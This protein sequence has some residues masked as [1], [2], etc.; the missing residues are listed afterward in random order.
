MYK[1]LNPESLGIAGR[2][3]ELIELTLT[4][5]YRGLDVDGADL[6]K[7]ASL[8]GVDEAA[9]YLRSG[10]VK[11]SGF[12]LP[13]SITAEEARYKT[14]LEKLA[15]QAEI[16]QQLGFKY[17]EMALDPASDSLPYVTNFEKHRERLA[18]AADLLAKHE[19]CV[20]LSLKAAVAHRQGRAH[21]FIHKAEEVLTLMKTISSTNIAL[22]LD[23][24]NWR[25]G[26][27]GSDQ[28]EQLKAHQ[29]A[30]V[31]IADVPL[32][33]DLATVT[34][35]ERLL[36]TEETVPAHA[37]LLR[38]LAEREYEGPVTLYPHPNQVPAANRDVC[39]QKISAQLDQ[40]WNAAGLNKAGRLA[41][42]PA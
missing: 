25:V 42:A 9:R 29:I 35:S 30:C 27:G 36:P 13:I 41:T 6:I 19:I 32:D 1:N 37:A 15:K 28:L 38:S 23:T 12:Q 16:A 7:R 31:R 26:G 8:L 5:G 21:Q 3:S 22:V 34:D 11:V 2:Q 10:K 4:Y 14:D 20:A 17:A 39:V 24:W 18:K 33:A 40:I